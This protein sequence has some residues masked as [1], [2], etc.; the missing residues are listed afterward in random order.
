M[1]P[2]DYVINEKTMGDSGRIGI[3][4]RG[5]FMFRFEDRGPEEEA[6][7]VRYASLGR[8]CTSAHAT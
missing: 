4:R 5:P 1:R 3:V 7:N 2:G 8:L 6:V